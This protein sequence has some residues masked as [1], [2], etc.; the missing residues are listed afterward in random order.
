MTFCLSKQTVMGCRKRGF[1]KTVYGGEVIGLA[2]NKI[3]KK[4]FVKPFK[5]FLKKER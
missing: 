1:R 5:F 2:T 4:L 3:A